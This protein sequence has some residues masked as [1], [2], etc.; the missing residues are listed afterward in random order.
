MIRIGPPAYF[1]VALVCMA[2]QLEAQF[3]RGLLR[4]SVEVTLSPLKTPD[5]LL[6]SGTVRV[7][8]K[9]ASTAPTRLIDQLQAGI[10]RQ[11]LENDSRLE[12][13]AK[14]AVVVM[15]TVTEWSRR[16]STG[17][18]YVSQT[19]QI[20]TKQEKD[21]K[22]NLKTVPVYE[23]GHNEPTVVQRG[24]ASIRLEVRHA[25]T[26]ALLDDLTTRV[27]YFDETLGNQSPPSEEVAEQAMIDRAIR[28]AAAKLSPGREP[29]RV[30]F[31][32]S[33]EVDSLNA[34]ARDR[35]WADLV[36]ALQ[37]LPPYRDAKR[38]A[39]RLHNLGVA[40]EAIAYESQN[41]ATIR[42]E[43]QEAQN[44]VTQAVAG[45]KDE[46]YFVEAANR[47][48]G[49]LRAVEWLNE[50]EMAL[51][52]RFPS[53]PT[54][55]S[56][57]RAATPG[58]PAVASTLAPPAANAAKADEQMTNQD[59]I[60]LA[61]AGL[62]DKLLVATI[63]DAKAVTFDLGPSGLRALLAGKVSNAVITVMRE[64]AKTR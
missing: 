5:T 9:N 3:H 64:R 60:D 11:I 15:A 47:I 45:K 58:P 19:R 38:D 57:V 6:P 26:E 39:Y 59:V 49:S 2:G 13:G 8:I 24:S 20:G 63:R 18:K 40:H 23:Y 21:S 55:R 50:R 4:D 53:R 36:T 61:K 27:T 31:A 35:R 56:T 10:S 14:P 32:R 44:L 46:K 62:D 41:R 12:A 52:E 22:G 30:M 43:L 17:T 33:D 37:Q 54:T 51:A 34:L 1:V 29:T 16:R 25:A 48:A 28:D 7:D 42:T